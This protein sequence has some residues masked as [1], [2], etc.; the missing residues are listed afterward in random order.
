MV[1]FLETDQWLNVFFPP[2]NN[3]YNTLR[4]TLIRFLTDSK[5]KG[6][7]LDKP[8]LYVSTYLK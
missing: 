2:D 4:D 3:E 8:N 6:L 7:L 5:V 1:G